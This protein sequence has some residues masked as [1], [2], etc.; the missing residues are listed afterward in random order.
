MEQ[1]LPPHFFAGIIKQTMKKLFF[2]FALAALT[3]RGAVAQGSVQFQ[4]YF[5]AGDPNNAPVFDVNGVLLAGPSF[6]AD[7]LYGSSASTVTGDAGFAFGFGPISLSRAGYFIG[8]EQEIPL[9]GTVFMRIVVWQAA[10]GAS[11]ATATG[12]ATED[13][14]DGTM[15]LENGG[16][17]WGFGNIFSANVPVF[18]N[19]GP[20]FKG[21]IGSFWLEVP[22]VPEPTTVALGGLGAATLLLFRRRKQ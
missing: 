22:N 14:S 10:A 11:W 8:G 19:P 21:L 18:P 17:E 13:T 4:N 1:N 9:T 12:G 16:T 6:Q 5:T 3:V 2:T 20:T 7:L 15:Y